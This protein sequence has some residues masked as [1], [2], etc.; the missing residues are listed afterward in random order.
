MSGC[1]ESR[2]R[3]AGWGRHPVETCR[4]FRPEGIEELQE[5]VAE[6]S[7]SLIARG[8]G[9]SYG[10]AALNPEGVLLAR[11]LD[12]LLD[13]DAGTGVLHCEAGVSLAEIL[14]VFLPRGF[15][16]PV[17]PGSKQVTVGGAIARGHM[18]YLSRS[19]ICMSPCACGSSVRI[20]AACAVQSGACGAV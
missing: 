15:F 5:V 13:F 7:G 18:H 2:E 14:D 17:T 16:F 20:A 9:R 12:R 3:L 8:L 19:V 4:V 11:R 1:P 10:D 6:G